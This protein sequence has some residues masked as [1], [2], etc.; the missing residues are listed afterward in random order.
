MLIENNKY[1][2]DG[3]QFYQRTADALIVPEHEHSAHTIHLHIRGPVTRKVRSSGASRSTVLFQDSI[4]LFP[5]GTRHAVEFVG[6][7]DQLVF[8]VTAQQL[9][10][11]L[12]ESL[13]GQSIRVQECDQAVDGRLEHLIR[14]LYANLQEGSPVG[15]MCTESLVASIGVCIAQR[16][17]SGCPRI[18][19]ANQGMPRV[20]LNRVFA[21]V[22]EKL[23]D[24]IRLVELAEA[25]GMSVF[26]FAKM[27]KKS[28]GQSPY[29]Y[30]M[31]RRI[32]TAKQLLRNQAMSVLEVSVRTGF[33]DQ[34]HFTKVFRRKIGVSPTEFR[35]AM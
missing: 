10:K 19:V 2:G 21:L 31:A 9:E 27:F 28:T 33:V 34:R 8:N 23:A 18:N 32:E 16:Y 29:Q 15:S 17:S 3:F 4:S 26:H 5:A 6:I 25:A 1:A 22:E 35:A 14:A 30:V 13:N 20:R 12:S 24:N 11:S 7:I